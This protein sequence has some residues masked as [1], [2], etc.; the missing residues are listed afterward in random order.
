MEQHSGEDL[1]H[2]KTLTP[3][4]LE[5]HSFIPWKFEEIYLDL[6]NFDNL[7]HMCQTQ[8]SLDFTSVSHSEKIKSQVVPFVT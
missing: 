2:I 5:S 3:E 1:S 4:C 6:D 7:L 8:G